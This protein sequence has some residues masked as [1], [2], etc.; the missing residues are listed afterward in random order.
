LKENRIEKALKKLA[1]LD[2]DDPLKLIGLRDIYECP[3]CGEIYFGL[4]SYASHTCKK[5]NMTPAEVSKLN[6]GWNPSKR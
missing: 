3:I 5:H 1:N 2:K 6:K 4:M